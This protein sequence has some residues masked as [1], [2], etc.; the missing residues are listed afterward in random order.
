MGGGLVGS[1]SGL[2]SLAASPVRGR[3]VVHIGPI[4]CHYCS[5]SERRRIAA[6]IAVIV[7]FGIL[8]IWR[9]FES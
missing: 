9:M 8:L 5:V 6:A 2:I 3:C 4:A 1:N 7:G